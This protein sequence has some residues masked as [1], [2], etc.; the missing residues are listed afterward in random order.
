MRRLPISLPSGRLPVLAAVIGALSLLAVL[1]GAADTLAIGIIVGLVYG[2]IATGLV[3]IYKGSRVVNFAHGQLATLG[4][5]AAWG[6][7]TNPSDIPGVYTRSTVPWLL[8][9]AAGVLVGGATGVVVEGTVIRRLFRAPRLIVLVATLGIGQVV[10]LIVYLIWLRGADEAGA[11]RVF[12]TMFKVAWR[13]GDVVILGEHVL[14]AVVVPAVALGL[15]AFFKLTRVGVAIRAASDNA[16]AARLLGV[17]VR[18]VSMITW[19]LGAALAAVAGILIAPING[20]LSIELLGT[21]LL[22]R[23]LA[24]AIIGGLTSLP[25][26]LLGG[27]TVGIAEVLLTRY[28]GQAMVPDLAG[29]VEVSLFAGILLVL[30]AV[31]RSTREEGE[32]AFTPTIRKVPNWFQSHWTIGIPKVSGAM[33]LAYLALAL[34][35]LLSPSGNFTYSLMLVYAMLGVSLNLLMG[36]AGQISLGHFALLGVGAFAGA[37]FVTVAGMPY[38]LAFAFAGLAGGLVAFLI[39]LPSLRIRG[40]YLAMATLAFAVAAEGSFFRLDLFGARRGISLPR[41]A[42]GPFDLDH[43]S[44]REMSYFCLAALAAFMV[45]VRNVHAR[46][47][48][49]ALLAVRDNERSAAVLGVSVRGYKLLAF[50]ISGVLAAWAGFFYALLNPL[51]QF[52]A[53]SPIKSLE[54]VAMVIIGGLGSVPGAVLGALYVVGIPRMFPDSDIAPLLATGFGLLL[55]LM[56]R[57]GGLWSL[58]TGLRDF[59]VWALTVEDRAFKGPFSHLV[60]EDVPEAARLGSLFDDGEALPAEATSRPTPADRGEDIRPAEKAA[61]GSAR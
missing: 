21:G 1:L 24:A 10:S 56:T 32:L 60:P 45:V 47:S 13:V 46:R 27:L 51:V 43:P 22:V 55:V 6:L 37:R 26:A 19:G 49:R 25:G 14:A 36:T 23:A 57:P 3:I 54:L 42:I 11:T 33:V 8:A 40:L 7:L 30:L 16:D 58:L 12:P 29:L 38:P 50:T 9:A 5:F 15:A 20:G 18:R 61:A 53:F 31:A 28:R 34:P 4:T 41:P 59:Y 2:M 39:G 52:S 17:S 44:G 35:L 48:G